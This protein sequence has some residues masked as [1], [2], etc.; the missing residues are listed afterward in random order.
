MTLTL[1]GAEMRLCRNI[2]LN[3]PGIDDARNAVLLVAAYAPNLI[4]AEITLL[5]S[6]GEIIDTA[7][8]YTAMRGV[9]T[10]GGRFFLNEETLHPANGPRSRLLDRKRAERSR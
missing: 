7:S 5:D 1:S 2:Q 10:V 3:D 6:T 4:D 8:S 9:G